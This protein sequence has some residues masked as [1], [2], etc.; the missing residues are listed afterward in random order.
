MT[1]KILSMS[2]VQSG[3]HAQRKFFAQTW[4]I[5]P[6]ARSVAGALLAM[7]SPAF[8]APVG[9][10][11]TAGQASVTRSGGATLI[12]QTSERAAIHWQSFNIGAGESVRFAQP[13]ASSI[14][15]N[16]VL[17]Q[18]ASEIDG[19]L[20]ANGQIF[21]LNPHG[22]LFGRGAQV[23]VGG[24]VASTLNLSDADFMA[25]RYR[26]VKEGGAGEVRNAGDLLANGGYVALLGPRVVN[27]GTIVAT[28]GSVALAAGEQ[29]TLNLNGNKL[30]GLTVERGA[31]NALAH[32]SGLIRADAGQVLL[33]AK[34]ADQLIKSVVNN[35]G[36]IEAGTLKRV[37]GEIHLVGDMLTHHGTLR[38][39][40]GADQ[41]GGR[42]QLT[43]ERD[44]T[45]A[46][47]SQISA[48]GARGGAVTAQARGGTLL[49]EGRIEA[50]GNE[51]TGGSVQLL[52]ERV[53]LLA[54]ASVN[55]S[56]NN[57]GG[58]ALIGGD[59]QGKS[60]AVQNAS[61]TVVA[62]GASIRADAITQGDGGKVIVWADG[63][64]RFQGQISAQGGALSGNGGLV[65]V[66]GKNTLDFAGTVN[67]SA[68]NGQF[69]TLLL[70]P[71]NITVVA[72]AT[73]NPPNAGDGLWAFGEDAGNQN[74]GAG[75][76]NT[77][78]TANNLTLQATNNI[79]VGSAISYTGAADRTLTLQANNN[80]TVSSAIATTAGRL[81]LVFN[82]DAD[83]S[84]A[85]TAA[86]NNNLTTRGGTVTATGFSVTSNAGGLVSTVGA[87][88][89][90]L[91]G[92]A[93]S[94]TAASTGAVNFTKPIN[95]SGGTAAAASNGR[96]A[97]AVNVSGGTVQ[98]GVITASG[99]AGVAAGARTGGAGGNVTLDATGAAP[100]ITMVGAITARGG[101]GVGG[102]A[103]GNGGAL[104]IADPALANNNLTINTTQ[105]TGG[106]PAGGNVTFASTLDSATATARTLNVAAGTG[107]IAF[108]GAV[109]ATRQLQTVTANGRTVTAGAVRS[110][111]SQSYT[112]PNGITLTGGT[113]QAI[114]G[115]AAAQAI[116]FNGPVTLTGVTTVQTPGGAAD[117]ISFSG[118]STINGAQDLSLNA[119]AAGNVTLGAA[120]GGS[121]PLNSMTASGA[122]LSLRAV[123]TS[124]SQSYTGTGVTLNGDLRSNGTAAADAIAVNGPVTLAGN[125]TVQ[126]S[127]A[128]ADGIAFS[129]TI[130]GARVFV[131]NANA[132]LGAV[133]FG[134]AVGQTTALTSFNATGG[135]L[136]MPA[137]RAGGI[138]ERSTTGTVTLNGVQT[139]TGGGNSVVI[140]A[141]TDFINNV[142]AGAIVPGT[143]RWLVYSTSPA[144]ST[145]NGLTAATGSAQPR[146][147]NRTLTAN[148]P[149]SI[150]Q[151]GN[152]LI[153][154]TQPAL[155]VSANNASR[156]YGDANPAF[157]FNTSGLVTDD[158]F[159]D[160]LANAG[161]SGTP[162]LTTTAVPNSPV[163]GS[164]YAITAAPGT[165][166]SSAGYGF[167]FVN[168]QLTVTPRPVTVTANAG[169]NKVYGNADPALT[170]TNSSLGGGDPLAGALARAAGENVGAYAINQGSVTNVTNPN[171]NISFAGNSFNITQRP[172][173]VSAA[174]DTKVY[175]GGIASVAVPTVTAGSLAFS[176]AGAFTQTFDSKNAGSGKT[177][178]AS[179]VVNDGNGGNNYAVTF[180]T[181]NTGVITPAAISGVTGITANNKVYDA[182]SAATLNTG[183]AGFTGMIG[184]DVLTAAGATG[185]FT[186]KNAGTGKTVNIGGITL[187]GADAGN[188]TLTNNTATATA[189]ITP[190]T[191]NV[192]YGG[193]NKVYDGTTVATVTTSDNRFAGDV[194]GINRNANFSDA[195][196]GVG[197]TV[198]VSGVSLSGAD[199][200]NYVV[201]A[202][203]ATIADITTRGIT[204]AANDASKIYGNAD[205]TLTFNIGGAGL[206]ATD[207]AAGV[208]GGALARVPGENVAGSPYAIT[209]GTLAAN[210]NYNVTAFAPGSFTITPRA[211]TIA[212]DNKAGAAGNP[213]PPFTASY[214]G[215]APGETPASLAGVLSF[216][217]PASAA[218]PPGAYAIVPSGQSSGNYAISYV[219][220][221][222]LLTAGA[223][224]IPGDVLAAA[225]AR[226]DALLPLFVSGP[227][228]LPISFAAVQPS[229]AT[230][231]ATQLAQASDSDALSAPGAGP[232]ASRGTQA[233]DEKN[234]LRSG[235]V[236]MRV[237]IIDGGVRLPGAQ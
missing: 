178:S 18:S 232:A 211:L 66:S 46:A 146:L 44:L 22:V 188:Y 58:S 222:L 206:A 29:A 155:T 233:D 208:F 110:N 225:N 149:A 28:N 69:G 95:T 107:N 51:G 84:G 127:G 160:T 145:E 228:A 43:A 153:Y 226:N 97:G 150:T 96:N 32:N 133:T 185:A 230:G 214:S 197:K 212:A 128:A 163:T 73:P 192:T 224:L 131:A 59:F 213:L 6:A 3:A 167:S 83:A 220:G 203:G 130:N 236:N 124:G 75:A 40:G 151:P 191:L 47:Q 33:T 94:L 234:P 23:N 141:A 111:G 27:E 50:T 180:I 12:Q 36:V 235:A 112:A 152:H 91:D 4:L 122:A 39:D 10:Q 201:A 135:S 11:V 171:Y 200:G 164:P 2:A 34:A 223:G 196:A 80:I 129:S 77:L 148:P 19:S 79:T 93:V 31:V 63:A 137:V 154:S 35:D 237:D 38:A 181:N 25:G 169:Q 56:G 190:A 162:S 189:N 42:I 138:T 24:L 118:T 182:T 20:S 172:I 5:H 194:L 16:R 215:L 202:S 219:N 109:G 101:N 132:N 165:L 195:N 60:P 1:R 217:T 15:L 90:N 134:G 198:N 67:T 115:T 179:G 139:A 186:D 157:T 72:G 199:A 209:Q 126:T 53:A 183:A 184:S 193:V 9:E 161:I 210:A 87:A 221:T 30:I 121:T 142:G 106:A 140:A 78:L 143:G 64:T 104:L 54:G 166:A 37:N 176:D 81:N 52:G 125:T 48:S 70:D 17:G 92:G 55:V 100:T 57:G 102:G 116:A 103:G 82:A 49:A 14:A 174:S 45:L 187:G 99:S 85:G 65:E 108:N 168:G 7:S 123:T 159:T 231:A 105:G 8:A 156:V 26:F 88:G 177:L 120:A 86:I 144:G 170:Y 114:T 74:I 62:P 136:A 61:R 227:V 204:V 113:L 117:N 205:P 216:F 207:T 76:I 13:S 98:I 119:G 41:N 89:L 147:Y 173:T 21:L 175:D 218:S 71:T 68:A 229:E 158:G